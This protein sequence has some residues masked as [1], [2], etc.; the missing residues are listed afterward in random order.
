M[1]TGLVVFVLPGW[2]ARIAILAGA[3]AAAVGLMVFHPSEA[4]VDGG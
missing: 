3:F 4:I 2:V 1:L